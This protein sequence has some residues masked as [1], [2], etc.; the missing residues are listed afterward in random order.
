MKP[1]VKI[2][3]NEEGSM[4]VMVILILVI[5]TILGFSA[6]RT[7]VLEQQIA[8][9]DQLHKISFYAA[10]SGAYSASKLLSNCLNF[11]GVPTGTAGLTTT[12][13]ENAYDSN[14]LSFST[15]PSDFYDIMMGY[16]TS[17]LD[18]TADATCQFNNSTASLDVARYGKSSSVVGGSAE[19]ATAAD[20]AGSGSTGGVQMHYG[21]NSTGSAGRGSGVTV[22]VTYRKVS[23]VPG[24]L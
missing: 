23:G 22:N 9:N 1:L 20:G 3:G 21:M 2:L 15:T 7:S 17:T 13:A 4:I 12:S 19:F 14:S 10:E 6:T 5:V 11:K 24:G 16:T 18:G 8:T